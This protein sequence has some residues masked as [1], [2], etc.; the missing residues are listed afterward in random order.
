MLKLTGDAGKSVIVEAIQKFRGARVYVYD[1]EQVGTLDAYFVSQKYFTVGEFCES[2]ERD[3]K[4]L[5]IE[6]LPV[7]TI[8]LYTNSPDINVYGELWGF[9]EELEENGL[10]GTTIVASK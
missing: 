6:Q 3:L 2:V 1:K 10:A 9:A 4:G 7:N 5:D 8:V